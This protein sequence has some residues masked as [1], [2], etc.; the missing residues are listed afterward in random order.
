MVARSHEK[1]KG[2]QPPRRINIFQR[3][4]KFIRRE[5]SKASPRSE[6]IINIEAPNFWKHLREYLGSKNC[7]QLRAAKF[8]IA[9][10]RRKIS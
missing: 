2:V 5:D 9:F 7:F 6:T 4:A 10:D 3:P 1:D 8:K